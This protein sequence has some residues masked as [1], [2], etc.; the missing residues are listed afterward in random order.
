MRS[1]SI[2]NDFFKQIRK[3]SHEDIGKLFCALAAVIDGGERPDLP[4]T[5]EMLSE[6]IQDQNERFEEQKNTYSQAQAARGKAGGAPRGNQNARKQPKSSQ[7][8]GDKQNK[9]TDTVTVT[10]TDTDTREQ[11]LGSISPFERGGHLRPRSQKRFVPPTLGEVAAYCQERG[12]AI[13]AES[14]VAFY[15][16]KNWYVGKNKMTSWKHA[17]I[18]WEKRE[19]EGRGRP[20]SGSGNPFLDMV[21]EGGLDDDPKRLH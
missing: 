8:S 16:S 12:N 1:V 21:R 15:T 2:H 5:L 19:G 17:I 14:F 3:H 10:V 6:M 11:H 9:P 18:M 20:T 7:T 4:P 13:D